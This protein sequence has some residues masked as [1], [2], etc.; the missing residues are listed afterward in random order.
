MIEFGRRTITRKPIPRI[1]GGRERSSITSSG[2]VTLRDSRNASKYSHTPSSLHESRITAL[3]SGEESSAPELLVTCHLED[4]G[5]CLTTRRRSV[6]TNP[7]L[8]LPK[9]HE[10][11]K[12]GKEQL[13]AQ[14]GSLSWQEVLTR[15]GQQHLYQALCPFS[16]QQVA[17]LQLPEVLPRSFRKQELT[18]A[19]E[20]ESRNLELTS[21]AVGIRPYLIFYRNGYGCWRS[22]EQFARNLYRSSYGDLSTP[23][24]S[25]CLSEH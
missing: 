22:L 16:N 19:K 8:R 13:G 9:K 18:Q 11:T 23:P 1:F 21:S 7:G 4:L 3:P 2:A 14:W 20:C 12:R 15:R 17:S 25:P 24:P 10:T 6:G 5:I